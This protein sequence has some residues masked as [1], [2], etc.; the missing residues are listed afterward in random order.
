ME[1][2]APG[3][4]PDDEADPR[5]LPIPTRQSRPANSLPPGGITRAN[6]HAELATRRCPRPAQDR[7][8]TRVQPWRHGVQRQATMTERRWHRRSRA[9]DAGVH[10]AG[11]TTTGVIVRGMCV[12]DQ[13]FFECRVWSATR[14]IGS[15]GSTPRST[16]RGSSSAKPDRPRQLARRVGTSS[17]RGPKQAGKGV[18]PCNDD[19]VS[20]GRGVPDVTA[21][22]DPNTGYDVVVDGSRTAEGGTSAV[23]PLYAGL[24]A[25]TNQSLGGPMGFHHA[26][27]L[28]PTKPT[29]SSISRAEPTRS[30]P[31]RATALVLD[32]T[33]AATSVGSMG[34]AFSASCNKCSQPRHH[35]PG[36]DW[37]NAVRPVPPAA[38]PPPRSSPQGNPPG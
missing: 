18:S 37:Q 35:R 21:D 24:C 10:H 17:A 25:L 38:R 28:Q 2:Q 16:T 5:W 31:L 26:V 15:V 11:S 6:D 36:R 32:G 29:P 13:D 7:G 27:Y 33:H 19:G 22:A 23:A 8:R 30:T 12:T 4:R 3:T 14:S 9:G 34:R 20:I 1:A